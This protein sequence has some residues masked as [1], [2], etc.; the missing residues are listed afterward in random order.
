VNRVNALQGVG[1]RI[2]HHLPLPLHEPDGWAVVE[3]SHYCY[4]REGGIRTLD[5]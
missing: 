2:A 5:L 3:Q 1:E 4:V